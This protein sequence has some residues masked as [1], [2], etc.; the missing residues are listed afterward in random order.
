MLKMIGRAYRE[1]ATTAVALPLLF[2]LPFAT[3]LIQHIIE[4]RA[5]MFASIEGMRAAGDDAG[6]M[7]FGQIKILSLILLSYWVSRWLAYGRD[8]AHKVL[9]DRRSA[10]LFFWVVLLDVAVGLVQQFGGGLLAPYV[11]ERTLIALG[12]ALFVFTIVLALYLVAWKVGA[13]LGNARLTIPASFRLMHGNFWW[14]LAFYVAMFLP[15]MV[16]HYALNIVAVG[17]PAGLAW[18]ILGADALLVGYLGLLLS[19]T[20]FL[21]AA[22]AATRAGTTLT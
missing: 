14:S 16:A 17:K 5:G 20:T 9:G 19:T 6:R 21:I 8:P 4:Y 10:A 1:S 15:V 3:E 11:P 2:A 12:I 22:R 18:A 7:G 13:A